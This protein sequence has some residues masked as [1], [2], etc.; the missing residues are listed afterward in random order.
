MAEDVVGHRQM[1]KVQR[2]RRIDQDRREG[3]NTFVSCRMELCRH[4]QGD[5]MRRRPHR[6]LGS[7]AVR[8]DLGRYRKTLCRKPFGA[9]VRDFAEPIRN[10]K[11]GALR[12]P[13]LALDSRTGE[14]LL[15]GGLDF[16][17]AFLFLFS[18]LVHA[19]V[20]AS[21][22]HVDLATLTP[23]VTTPFG[24]WCRFQVERSTLL[25]RF[26]NVDTSLASSPLAE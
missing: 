25:L 21:Q 24:Q 7:S 2:R 1:V 14:T 23:C 17:V 20:F 4:N 5:S 6:Y 15:P 19:A 16:M 10:E 22:A 26:V 18:Y 3:R 9:V 8:D 11:Y 12:M 13:R